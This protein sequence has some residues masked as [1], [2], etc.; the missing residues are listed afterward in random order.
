MITE[1]GKKATNKIMKL[2]I[3]IKDRD[4]T[5]EVQEELIRLER[6]K[7]IG[8]EKS[9]SK[10]RKRFKVQEDLLKARINKILE[11]EGSLAKEKENIVNLTKDLSLAN[12]S[13]AQLKGSNETLHENFLC[14]HTKHMDLEVERDLFK[15][16]TPS[17]CNDATKSFVSI[18]SNGFAR[19]SNINVESCATNQPCG[20][21]CHEQ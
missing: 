17:S 14:L 4:E 10:E 3:E 12:E 7:T 11:L 5:L 6:E 19:C 21:V 15:E 18:S 1:L 9:L 20:D 16:S 2:L 13:N 8:L